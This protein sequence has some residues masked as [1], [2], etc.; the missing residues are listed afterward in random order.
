L[1]TLSTAL[2]FVAGAEIFDGLTW[3]RFGYHKG[4]TVYAQNFGATNINNGL[5][6]DFREL[7]STMWKENYYYLERLRDQ[8]IGFA[9]TGK[10]TAFKHV[11]LFLKDASEQLEARLMGEEA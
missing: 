3:L 5:L 9:R 6:Q 2:Y 1:D 8:M 7:A 4:Q 10:W 11:D